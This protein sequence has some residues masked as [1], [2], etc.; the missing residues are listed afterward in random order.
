MVACHAECVR[1]WTERLHLSGEPCAWH[2]QHCAR[3]IACSSLECLCC[4]RPC[5]RYLERADFGCVHAQ[6]DSADYLK[7]SPVSNF[8]TSWEEMDPETEEADDYGLGVV[9][10][11][12]GTVESI[13]D[14]LGMS[15][16]EG[17]D[18]V[19]A[20]AR[21]H[22]LMLSGEFCGGERVMAKISFGLDAKSELAMKVVTRG[23]SL[24]ASK[25]LH[26]VIQEA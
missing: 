5:Q 1:N 12:S 9:D 25:A 3:T 26:G 11:I 19:A 13:M 17:S 14:H 2:A 22:T 24:D 8:K 10:G 23:D 21:S 18:V 6:F 15:C 16:C 20:N 7:A 4:A